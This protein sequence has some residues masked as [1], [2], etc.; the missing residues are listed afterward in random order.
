MRLSATLFT[1]ATLLAAAF[2][3]P[4]RADADKEALCQAR[5][6]LVVQAFNARKEGETKRKVR[7]DMQA[8]LDRTAAEMLAEFVWSVP[9][10]ALT[11]EEIGK[12]G[13]MFLDQCKA[14]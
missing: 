3:A 4:A 6:D 2:A 7:R 13:A 5:A 14:L 12:A 11:E 8:A 1:C 10:E 9:E